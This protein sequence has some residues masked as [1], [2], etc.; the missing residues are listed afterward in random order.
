LL[1]ACQ[2]SFTPRGFQRVINPYILIS[3]FIDKNDIVPVKITILEY[4]DK[5]TKPKMHVAMTASKIEKS[6]VN[7]T[8]VI[9]SSAVA[10]SIYKMN[11]SQL[12]GLVND[13]TLSKYIPQRF[14]FYT[15]R[16][17]AGH[18]PSII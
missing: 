11:L 16:F 6:R 8:P 7:V 10:T 17:S 4:K 18:K 13:E 2:I 15:P 9:K 14:R 1:C 5:N 12:L 3:S